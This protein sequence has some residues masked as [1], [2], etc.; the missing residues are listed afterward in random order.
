MVTL[1]TDK[2]VN[3]EKFT[4]VFEANC[5][6]NQIQA[7]YHLKDVQWLLFADVQTF[8]LLAFS[9]YNNAWATNCELNP[10]TIN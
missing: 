5:I 10:Y 9:G 1:V 8:R 4:L 6:S 3:I 2:Q 7:G